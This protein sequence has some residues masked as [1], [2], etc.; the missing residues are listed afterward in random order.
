MFTSANSESDP[1]LSR[2]RKTDSKVAHR[3]VLR[4]LGMV[5]S[6]IS[7]PGTPS[8]CNDSC[9]SPR[10]ALAQSSCSSVDSPQ[11]IDEKLLA[12]ERPPPGLKGKEIGEDRC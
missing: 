2:N 5:P 8:P 11:E 4:S 3:M 10:N 6:P 7:S 9:P 12:A 1:T